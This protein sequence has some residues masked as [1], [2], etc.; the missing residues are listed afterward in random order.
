MRAAILIGVSNYFSLKNLN[1]CKSDVNLINK[2]LKATGEYE[3]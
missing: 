2:I 1:A 3:P